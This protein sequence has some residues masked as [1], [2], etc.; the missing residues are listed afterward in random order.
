M[1]QAASAT[2]NGLHET[3]GPRVQRIDVTLED[4]TS[5]A[6]AAT[7]LAQQRAEQVRDLLSF[8]S[9]SSE[10]LSVFTACSPAEFQDLQD[11]LGDDMNK[12]IEQLKPFDAMM[13][14]TLGP[15]VA[16]NDKLNEKRVDYI[17]ETVLD[18]GPNE[19]GVFLLYMFSRMYTSDIEAV[20]KLLADTK[21][22]NRTLKDPAMKA[23]QK[24]LTGRGVD[25]TKYKDRS[26]EAGD[27]WRAFSESIQA[28]LNS[29][30][31]AKGGLFSRQTFEIA[32]LP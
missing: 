24:Y 14:G 10:I 21:N 18:Y 29:S 16:A 4:L 30:E 7:Q 28:A 26:F 12:V 27:I 9:H 20:L 32:A 8:F 2:P 23:L 6:S 3:P 17:V 11:E 31:A 15:V 22:L 1:Q 25:L 5:T 13:L 19:A